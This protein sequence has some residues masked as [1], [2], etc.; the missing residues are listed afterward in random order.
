MQST[1]YYKVTTNHGEFCLELFSDKAP[2]TVKNF[3]RYVEASL[4]VD[5]VFNRIIGDFMI[6][7]GG[8]TEDGTKKSTFDPIRNEATNGLSNRKG[9]VAM[10]RHPEPH[11]ATS[12]FFINLE[13]N[14]SLNH[15]SDSDD[16]YGYAV[17]GK[18]SSGWDVVEKIGALETCIRGPDKNYPVTSVI[19]QKITPLTK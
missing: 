14:P 13:D 8:Y 2:E 11:S 7:G 4:Y 5:T 12:Q 18:V 16:E 3:R 19:I 9:F 17:F 6:Q 10:A 15:F 1:E